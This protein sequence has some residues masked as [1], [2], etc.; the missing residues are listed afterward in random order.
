MSA[1]LVSDHSEAPPVNNAVYDVARLRRAFPILGREVHG[2]PLTY[3]DNAATT[4]KPKAVL[5]AIEHHYIHECANVHRGAYWLSEKAS[6]QYEQ[7]RKDVARFIHAA[8]AK[9]IIFVRGATEAINLVAAGFGRSLLKPGDEIIVSEMEHHSN[10]VP[11]QMCAEQS[12]AGIKVLPFDDRGVLQVAELERLLSARTKLLAV[13]H[14]SNALGTVNPLKEIITQAHAHGV[15]VLVDGA[16]AIPHLPVDVV[17]LDADYYVFSGHKVYGPTGIGVL[18][19]K[20]E[21][22]ERLPPYQGGGDMIRTVSFEKTTYAPLPARFEA[23]TPDIAGAIGLGA[24][25]RFVESV[26]VEAISRHEA[27]LMAEAKQ[28]L[29]DI[30]GLRLIGTAPH[31]AGVISFTL[32]KVHPHDMATILD[33]QGIAVRAG[34]HCAQPVMKHFGV[35]ATARA[36][37]AMYNT[38][39]EV[40]ALGAALRHVREVLRP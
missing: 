4:Q 19:G 32:D 33:R 36:S 21:A 22:L 34:H 26:G 35:P 10:I 20:R 37:F 25:L 24:A 7:A 38:L 27:M 6:E 16:Q 2:H 40:Q 8:H 28:V 3:L 30:P 17:T 15:P 23:G 14:V 11:W 31:R 13:T 39:A 29:S 12:G 1:L 5:E 9:E 18:Y